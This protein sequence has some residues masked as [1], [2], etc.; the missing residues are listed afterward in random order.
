MDEK[1]FHSYSRVHTLT[2]MGIMQN[3]DTHGDDQLSTN[4][5]QAMSF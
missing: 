4:T 5:S 2:T 3:A 1:V